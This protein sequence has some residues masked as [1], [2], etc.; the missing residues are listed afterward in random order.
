MQTPLQA[1]SSLDRLQLLLP[2]VF[3]PNARTGELFLRFEL[4]RNINAAISLERIVETLRLPTQSITP[5]PNMPACTL[6]LMENQGKVF[7]A[8]DLAQA[9]GLTQGATRTREYEIIIIEA[10]PLDNSATA[11][12][13]AANGETLLLGLAV[14][15]IRSTLRLNASDIE[16]SNA[17]EVPP[18]LEPYIK[19]SF[20]RDDSQ[21][22]ILSVE[23]LSNAKGLYG[24]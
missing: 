20:Q 4:G 24:D 17:G 15:K 19:G 10:L 22:L 1:R 12:A 21:T 16:T 23:A 2:E 18:V 9:L 13:N 7:W 11:A 8:V 5:M 14:T 6:G 3:T